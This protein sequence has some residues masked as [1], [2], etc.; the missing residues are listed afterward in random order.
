LQGLVDSGATTS[1][2]YDEMAEKILIAPYNRNDNLLSWGGN[3]IHSRWA[4]VSPWKI[5]LV[6]RNSGIEYR[7]LSGEKN[8]GCQMRLTEQVRQYGAG[9]YRLTI[10][11]R[12][13]E[14]TAAR[15]VL[16]VNGATMSRNVNVK[17]DEWTT[18]ILSFNVENIASESDVDNA[19]IRILQTAD[20]VN[21]RFKNA[22]LEYVS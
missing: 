19:F 13:A 17:V 20:N 22:K 7:M 14:D 18:A 15:I 3:E 6:T 4:E 5:H 1:A 11:L 8:T 16:G 9:K 12:A 10:D 2:T 21:L